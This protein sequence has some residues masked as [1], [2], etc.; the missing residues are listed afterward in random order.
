M[1]AADTPYGPLRDAEH[2]VSLHPKLAVYGTQPAAVVGVAG[3]SV[4]TDRDHR[5]KLQFAWARGEVSARRLDRPGDGPMDRAGLSTRPEAVQYCRSYVR[6]RGGSA[7]H[8]EV[9]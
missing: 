2:G 1:L 3:Q 7:L 5:I 9:V 8:K 4:T 6:R